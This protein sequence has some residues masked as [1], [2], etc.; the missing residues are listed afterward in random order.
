MPAGPRL[1]LL[2]ASLVAFASG[3]AALGLQA[4]TRAPVEV[5]LPA[6]TPVPT[7]LKVHVSGAVVAPGV[8][9]LAPGDRVDDALRAAGGA[10]TGADLAQ[11]NLAA[12]VRDEGRVVVPERGTAV[13]VGAIGGP[14]VNLNTAGQAGLEALPGIGAVRAQRIVESRERDGP[15]EEPTDLV[16]RRLVTATIYQRIRELVTTR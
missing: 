10:T 9:L 15:F 3:V 13:P 12:R 4:A 11:L 1:W 7:E 14:R 5:V 16:S 6:P 2:G 8:Y